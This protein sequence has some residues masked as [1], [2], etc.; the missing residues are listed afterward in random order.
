MLALQ[1][2]PI[3]DAES[4]AQFLQQAMEGNERLFVQLDTAMKEMRA[5]ANPARFLLVRYAML[6]TLA[7]AYATRNHTLFDV[8]LDS[9]FTHPLPDSASAAQLGAD[10]A[11][12][13][14]SGRSAQ[15]REFAV[16]VMRATV[17]TCPEDLQAQALALLWTGASDRAATVAGQLIEAV[18]AANLSSHDAG[19][20]KAWA[21]A[22]R[23]LAAGSAVKLAP[24]V[25]DAMRMRAVH[26][27]RLLGR[28]R[29]GQ[30]T[31]LT[32]VDFWDSQTAALLSLAH[33]CGLASSITPAV[34]PFADW[35][36]A[37]GVREW[38]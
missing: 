4:A 18:A 32:A 15:A 23:A 3:G 24:A 29:K 28:W 27:N 10:L 7:G 9:L 17:V 37:E 6:E 30:D 14:G 33:T 31:E 12:A 38:A 21:L 35:R 22:A 2:Y 16:R 20:L 8:A 11:A 1:S 26:V 5:T 34:V 25:H 36:W 19:V 13:A